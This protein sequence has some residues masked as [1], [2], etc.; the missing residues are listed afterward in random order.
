MGVV[1]GESFTEEMMAVKIREEDEEEEV[2]GVVR[3]ESF[4]E[5]MM[6]VNIMEEDEVEV[7]LEDLEVSNLEQEFKNVSKVPFLVDRFAFKKF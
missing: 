7:V 6:A 5:E 2:V 4:T 1:H 3:A